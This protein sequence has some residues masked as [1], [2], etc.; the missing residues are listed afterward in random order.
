MKNILFVF[1]VFVFGGI[2]AYGQNSFTYEEEL[3][4]E[5]IPEYDQYFGDIGGLIIDEYGNIFFAENSFGR[6]FMISRDGSLKNSFSEKGRGPGEFQR[7]NNLLK[8]GTQLYVFDHSQS[9]MMEF[10]YEDGN[11]LKEVNLEQRFEFPNGFY[12]IHDNFL[13]IGHNPGRED[14]SLFHLFDKDFNYQSSGGELVS[15]HEMPDF[16]VRAKHQ[17]LQ[18]EVALFD[19]GMFLLLAAPYLLARYD[20]QMNK[21]WVIREE[22]IPEP[23]IDH[24]EITS[25]RYRVERYPMASSIY[26]ISD[27]ELLIQWFNFEKEKS[28]LDIRKK[29]DG[30]LSE[31]F[32]FNFDEIIHDLV[33]VDQ[34]SGFFVTF[35]R[36]DYSI[37]TYTWSLD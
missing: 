12:K 5:K 29:E 1:S 14:F 25:D 2:S 4:I 6:I 33:R 21:L 19:T 32:E 3:R 17:F 35:D 7:V 31:R 15:E 23:W 34:Q 37:R 20:D 36:T 16:M 13:I 24:I 28:R 26:S 8:A 9:K 30:A 10:D 27:S 11:L 22:V 18:G